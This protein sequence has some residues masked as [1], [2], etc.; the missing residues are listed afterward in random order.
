VLHLPVLLP[1]SLSRAMERETALDRGLRL[2]R[3]RRL[4]RL[5]FLL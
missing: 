5:L 2:C 1:R 4:L 3:L